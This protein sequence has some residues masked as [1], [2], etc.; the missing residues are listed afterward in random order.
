LKRRQGRDTH[1]VDVKAVGALKAASKPRLSRQCKSC[2]IKGKGMCSCWS[3]GYAKRVGCTRRPQ[4]L[5]KYE[6]E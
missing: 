6:R 2:R 3:N 1:D 4:Q 5:R